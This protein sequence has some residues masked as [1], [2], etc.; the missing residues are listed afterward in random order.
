MFA[1]RTALPEQVV[2][3]LEM[4]KNR[5]GVRRI[6]PLLAPP[7]SAARTRGMGRMTRGVLSLAASVESSPRERLRGYN[8]VE[9]E[10]KNVSAATLE[11]IQASRAV[12]FVERVPNRW[13]SARAA[14]ADPSLNLQ[15]G[16]RAIGWFA[17]KRRPNAAPVHVAVLDTGVDEQHPD[18]AGVIASY[19][20]GGHS[21][22]DLP[23]HGTHVSGILAARPNNGIGICGVANCKLHVWK[24]FTDPS[25]P[26]RLEQFDDEGYNRALG[27]VL[28]SPA[29]IVNLS[30]G[31]TARSRTEEDLIAALVAEGALV[32][33]AMGNEYDEGNPVEYPAAYASVLAVGAIGENRKRVAFSCT[34]RHI[35]LVAPGNNILST[36]PRYPFAGRDVEY[37][38]WPGTSMASP[39]VAGCAALLKAKHRARDGKWIAARLMN[40]AAKLG[41]MAGKRF[42]AAYGHGLVNVARALV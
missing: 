17:A 25:G 33:A 13:L 41:A 26:R 22:K 40:T 11:K 24:V 3:P 21:A 10:S 39:H 8:V 27:A 2:G 15:W 16:L 34:G 4:L 12:Q 42:T 6:D 18:L 28:D 38:S 20:R 7:P 37:D 30:L 9:L 5:F 29:K 1:L 14:P 31:G 36:V 32:V 23:G 19:H 35:G